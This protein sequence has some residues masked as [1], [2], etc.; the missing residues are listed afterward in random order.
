MQTLNVRH[1]L[2]AENHRNFGYLCIQEIFV[3]TKSSVHT[4]IRPRIHVS[5]GKISHFK[6][7]PRVWTVSR[8]A[9]GTFRE[10]KKNNSAESFFRLNLNVYVSVDN[11]ERVKARDKQQRRPFCLLHGKRENFTAEV[12]KREMLAATRV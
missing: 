11:R 4:S 8:M 2:I 3:A 9:T 10:K 7:R 6:H 1:T 12:K 5:R